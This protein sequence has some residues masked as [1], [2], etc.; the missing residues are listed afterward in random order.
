MWQSDKSNLEL[1]VPFAEISVDICRY[2]QIE[3]FLVSVSKS[4]DVARIE[5]IGRALALKRYGGLISFG[6]EY[7]RIT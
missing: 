7:K 4:L 3:S 2:D 5:V 6:N 1:A